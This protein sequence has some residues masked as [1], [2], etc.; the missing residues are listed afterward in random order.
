MNTTAATF[1]A[2]HTCGTFHIYRQHGKSEYLHTGRVESSLLA[3]IRTARNVNGSRIYAHCKGATDGYFE[4]RRQ[5]PNVPGFV[6]LAST[7]G[8]ISR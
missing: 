4:C 6:D 7:T 3:A 1:Q 2:A 8:F 5:N